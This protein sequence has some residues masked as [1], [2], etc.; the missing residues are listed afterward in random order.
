VTTPPP[1]PPTTPETPPPPTTPAT[2]ETLTT[3]AEWIDWRA[4]GFWRPGPPIS[5]ADFAAARHNLFGGAFTW[6]VM[7]ARRTAIERNVAALAAFCARHGL[8]FAPHGKTT[9]APSL[10]AAQLRAGAWAITAATANQVLAYRSFGVPRVLL[11]NQLLDPAPLRWIAEEVGRGMDFLCFVDSVAGVEAIAEA[12]GEAGSRR[13]VRVLAELGHEGGRAGCR[14]VTE[15][16]E[17]ARAAVAAPG[18]ELA[19]VGGY[20]GVLPGAAEVGEYLSRLR[21]ATAELSAKGLLPESVIVTAGGSV[22]FDLVADLLA[23]SWLPGHELRVILRSG[24][25]VTHDDGFYRHRTPFARRPEE[26]TLE[27]ALEV[28]AQV[29]STPEDHLAIAGMGKREA[30]YDEGLPVPLRVRRRD[31]LP[32][33]HRVRQMAGHPRGGGRLHGLRPDPHVLL[34]AGVFSR[35]AGRF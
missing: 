18:L 11:A 32:P 19:G 12:V 24:A 27:A 14:T 35:P 20:E 16:T 30:P 28:W 31:D 6:P 25:Y 5:F 34:T 33:V 1:P 3:P 22:H 10:F 8:G 17:V 4:K 9:M 7:V 15:L 21:A 13:P 23:G 29:T 26:G 2:S